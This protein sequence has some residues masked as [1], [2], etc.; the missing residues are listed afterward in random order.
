M[1]TSALRLPGIA[2]LLCAAA[3]ALLAVPARAEDWPKWRGPTREAIVTEKNLAPSWPEGGPKELWRAKVGVG[4]ASP[5]VVDGKVYMFSLDQPN[6]Q[7][8]LECFGAADGKS[9][10]R[11]T[12]GNPFT[13]QYKGTRC[14]PVVEGDRIYTYGS[15]SQLAAWNLADGKQVWTVNVLKETGGKNQVWGIASNPLID[16]DRIYVQA[17]E[18][19]NAA[20]CVNKADGKIVWKS[21][22]QGGGYAPPVLVDVGGGVKHLLCFGHE[23]LIGLDPKTGTML[24]V[25]QEKWETQYNV[26][27]TMPIVNG[28]KVF[29]SVAYNNARCGLYE[30]TQSGA[31]KIWDG[32]QMTCRFNPPIFDNGYLYGNS[33]GRLKCVRW[34]DGKEMWTYPDRNVLQMGGSLLRYGDRLIVLSERGKLTLVQATPEACKKLAEMEDVVSGKFVWSTPAVSNGKLFI[35][36]QDELACFDISGK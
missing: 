9:I 10:W 33:E 21:E 27:A 32:N 12:Q 20:V 23:N 35:K 34:D 2:A 15:N 6:N 24:W 11:Q 28:N 3:L 18:T 14:S 13:G 36:G 5:V 30:I 25:L 17:G 4:Y 19:G 16:G 29:V 1:T 22:A 31:R 7:E 8:V 26:N